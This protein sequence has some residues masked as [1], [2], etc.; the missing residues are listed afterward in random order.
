MQDIWLNNNLFHRFKS[1]LKEKINS[2]QIK[3]FMNIM[4]KQGIVIIN[5]F[6]KSSLHQSKYVELNSISVLNNIFL[7]IH[8]SSGDILFHTVLNELFT[9]LFLLLVSQFLYLNFSLC[10]LN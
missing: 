7:Y 10:L 6:H 2:K 4:M 8:S 3:N 9:C 5:F 1:S